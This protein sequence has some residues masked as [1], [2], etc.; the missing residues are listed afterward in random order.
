MVGVKIMNYREIRDA[1]LFGDQ[2]NG[3]DSKLFSE[4]S[5]GKWK[6]IRE[7][8]FYKDMLNVVKNEGKKYL[9]T[10][11]CSVEKNI[12]IN[13][14]IEKQDVY[15]LDFKLKNPTTEICVE[16]EFLCK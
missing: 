3:K 7:H 14:Q 9:E 12:F 15:C 11:I 8:P 4:C 6:Q 1:L 5:P 13:H 10:P 16:F 2:K